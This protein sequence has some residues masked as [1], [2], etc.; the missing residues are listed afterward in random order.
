MRRIAL[1]VCIL[2]VGLL[3]GGCWNREELNELGIVS[4]KAVDLNDSGEWEASFQITVPRS[5]AATSQTSGSQSPVTVFS[6]KGRTMLEAVERAGTESPRRLFFP[7]IQVIV[8][9]ERVAREKGLK[10]V[11]ELYLRDHERRETVNVLIAHG[12]AR[13]VLD[14]LIPFESNP[15]YAIDGII[16]RTRMQFRDVPTRLQDL[17]MMMANPYGNAVAQEVLVS[18]DRDK[19]SNL[20]ALQSTRSAGVIK[21]GRMGVFKADKL[22]GWMNERETVGWAWATNHIK[23]MMLPFPCDGKELTSGSASSFQ[24]E[25]ASTKQK[26]VYEGKEIGIQLNIRAEGSV[27]EMACQ[28]D[29]RE[30][31][32]LRSLERSIAEAI[33]SDVES[34]VRK[35][36][37]LG[38]DVFGFGDVIHR[39]DRQAWSVLKANWPSRIRELSIHTNV[40]V[41]IRRIGLTNDPFTKVLGNQEDKDG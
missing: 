13:D 41:S 25:T 27:S 4:A 5:T 15:A 32:G 10:A 21:L 23:E 36:R 12:R 29:F 16:R 34:A 6:A 31:E 35:A 20:D 24:V 8:I 22:V 28:T 38:A 37:D 3:L 40:E 11:L 17:I 1:I 33:Q 2:S 30:A 14:V 19:Q 18:G 39:T 9:S 7:H 26:A